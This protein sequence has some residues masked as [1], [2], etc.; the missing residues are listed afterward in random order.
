MHNLVL[1]IPTCWYLKTRKFA[2]P[3]MPN[4]K[5]ALSPTRNPNPSQWNIGCVGYQTQNLLVGNVHLKFFV[6]ISFAFG[7]QRKPSFQ[8]NNYGLC[9]IVTLQ[10]A[11]DIQHSEYCHFL[12]LLHETFEGQNCKWRHQ[13]ITYVTEGFHLVSLTQNIFIVCDFCRCLQN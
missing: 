2:L 7:G 5:F 13:T 6:V 11:A 9:F 8:W 4:L 12:K 10:I 1:P 3:P